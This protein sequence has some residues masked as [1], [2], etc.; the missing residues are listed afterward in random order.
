MQLCV[1]TV[2][3]WNI[4]YTCDFDS[5]SLII[6]VAVKFV[7]LLHTAITKRSIVHFPVL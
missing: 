6:Y 5:I 2:L 1:N 7:L 3:R 4:D